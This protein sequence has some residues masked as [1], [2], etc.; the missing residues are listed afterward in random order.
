ME[1]QFSHSDQDTQINHRAQKPQDNATSGQ[2]ERHCMSD[3]LTPPNNTL[4]QTKYICI[5][6]NRMSGTRLIYLLEMQEPVLLK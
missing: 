1:F 3:G 2:Q 4:K 5:L 6:K